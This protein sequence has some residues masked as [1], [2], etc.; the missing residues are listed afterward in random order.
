MIGRSDR[1]YGQ[2][3]RF[4]I[5][6][7]VA[8][9]LDAIAYR[10]ILSA[11]PMGI[12]KAIGYLVGMTFSISCNYRWSFGYTGPGRANIVA[13]C[14]LLYASALV[15]NVVTNHLVAAVLPAGPLTLPAA[16]VAAVGV[17]TIYNFAGM[18]FWIFR[19]PNV[20]SPIA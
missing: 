10:I 11:A 20:S 13:R 16:F 1:L 7:G 8:T 17:C 6:G 3:L 5:V 15:L 4:V 12:A 19:R 14:V 18:R 2:F 9:I